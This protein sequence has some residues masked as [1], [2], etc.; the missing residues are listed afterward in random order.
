M[1]EAVTTQA[2]ELSDWIA[3]LKPRV[4]TLVVFT[5]WNILDGKRLSHRIAID[6]AIA[7]ITDRK[8]N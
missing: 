1:S 3:L 4:M 7:A 8:R 6:K 5:G 2:A